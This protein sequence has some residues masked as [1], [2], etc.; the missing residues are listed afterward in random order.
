[1]HLDQAPEQARDSHITRMM[2]AY[3]GSLLRMCFLLLQDGD[4][5][6]DAVQETFLKAYQKWESFRG[7][8]EE[9][10]WL[11]RIA[12][13][14]CKD[15]RRTAWFKWVDRKVNLDDFPE[16]GYLQ[17]F[18]D[19]TLLQAVTALPDKYRTV[20]LLYYYQ[21]MTQEQI[22]QTLGI[23]VSTV[24]SRLK[25]AKDRLREHLKGW[26]PDEQFL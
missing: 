17:R 2:E 7:E 9:L 3:G 13:N 22:A 14:T 8:S 18:R 24:K 26:V 1:M 6:R 4:Q 12:I 25:R 11:T 15:M 16:Q 10:T 5:A 19:N 20:V 23:P 21:D